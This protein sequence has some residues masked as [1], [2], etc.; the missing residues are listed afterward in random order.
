MRKIV[1]SVAILALLWLGYWLAGYL[2]IRTAARSVLAE[3]VSAGTLEPGAEATAGG[4][5]GAFALDLANL[6][7]Q[8]AD[9]AQGWDAPE[10]Q[11]H[12]PAWAPWSAE[13]DLKGHLRV[14]D[15]LQEI[16]L[17][18]EGVETGLAASPRTSLP[19]ASWYAEGAELLL[20][21]T[22]GWSLTAAELR[23]VATRAEDDD[24]AYV[25][26]GLLRGLSPDPAFLAQLAG[27]SAL[28]DVLGDIT[29]AGRVELTAPLDRM[30]LIR[31][32][33]VK[34]V[35]L[36]GFRAEWG[37][38]VAE[39]SGEVTAEASG[40][41]EGRIMIRI[42]N[43][44]ELL[45]ALRAGGAVTD[46]FAPTAERLLEALAAASGDPDVLDMPLTFAEGFMSLGPFP[47]GPAP[48]LR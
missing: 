20:S 42:A 16:T 14:T 44:R 30:A 6:R 48:L 27:Q 31:S 19:L 38:V 12:V 46:E 45:P 7:A 1:W 37:P 41:A 24:S 8:A 28:P 36:D 17:T 29:L 34:R 47:L 18:G 5:P 39:A 26:T 32:P 40:L 4:F 15:A 33:G 43:W 25:L 2:L 3:Q 23:L 10:V 9:G 11:L 21:S 13:L 35:L 22:L